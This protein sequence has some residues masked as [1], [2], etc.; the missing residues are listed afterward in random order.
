MLNTGE[1]TMKT[2]YPTPWPRLQL[3]GGSLAWLLMGLLA[4]AGLVELALADLIFL[5]APL[6]TVPL[7]VGLVDIPAEA[8]GQR[9][10]HRLIQALQP[11]GA[12]AAAGAFLWPQGPVAGLLAAAWLGVTLLIAL[13]GALRFLAWQTLTVAGIGINAGLVYLG[14]GGGW[15]VLARLGL[16][17]LGFDDTIVFL[18]AIHFHYAGFAAPVLAGLTSQALKEADPF[19][20]RWGQGAVLGLVVGTPLVAAGITLSPLL[21]VMGA[22]VVATSLAALV[23]LI[24]WLV[25][26]QVRSRPAQILLSISG[27][28]VLF[29]LGL[30]YLYAV[31]EFS[32]YPVI[33]IPRMIQLHGVANSLG[34]ALCGLLG[35]T[36]LQEG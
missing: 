12:I 15:F 31:G 30:I 27:L 14:V 34:F 36:L 10:L 32:G 3:G 13:L 1:V 16:N 22:I 2:A 9:Y 25:L 28:S 21:E 33:T 8:T 18:T 7:G 23:Y 17:P 5:L 4:A 20:R 6:V 35:W 24:R 26:F 29:G 11:V 19:R